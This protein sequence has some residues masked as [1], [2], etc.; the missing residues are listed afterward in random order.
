MSNQLSIIDLEPLKKEDIASRTEYRKF[1]TNSSQLYNIEIKKIRP[2]K[3]FNKREFF[4]DL[5][6]LGTSIGTVGQIEPITVDLLKDE[7]A[8]LVDGER[9]LLATQWW[10]ENCEPGQQITHLRAYVN[11]LATSDQQRY[12]TQLIKNNGNKPLEALEEARL[13]QDLLGTPDENGKFLKAADIARIQ[14]VSKMHVSNALKL[15]GISE[16]EENAIKDGL[17]SPTA[18]TDLIKGGVSEEDRKDLIEKANETGDKIKVEDVKNL[19]DKNWEEKQPLLDDDYT[20]PETKIDSLVDEIM[21]ETNNAETDH[22]EIQ[23]AGLFS[24]NNKKSGGSIFDLA[25]ESIVMLNGISYQ[26]RVCA[27]MET[28]ETIK[29]AHDN[30]NTRI[31]TLENHLRD[32]Q[33]IAKAL[34]NTI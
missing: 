28:P 34:T 9:R 31:E 11:L 22:Q 14:N 6:G 24:V 23:D 33:R 13:Y 7:T 16:E 26:G 12:I 2:R 29:I 30:L 25:T 19:L 20:K 32:I 8:L 27:E 15:I 5:S 21:N 10:N 3:G 18:I 17:I 1:T 4:G